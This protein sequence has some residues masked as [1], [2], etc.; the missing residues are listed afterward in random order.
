M[1]ML[2]QNLVNFKAELLVKRHVI[3]VV[4]LQGHHHVM[5]VCVIHR[6]L[7]QLHRNAVVLHL[8]IHC[9]INHVEAVVFME[10]GR[11]VGVQIVPGGEKVEQGF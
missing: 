8:G 7:Q 1:K 9:Q 4:G 10:L 11:P 2:F 5:L 3:G 6:R